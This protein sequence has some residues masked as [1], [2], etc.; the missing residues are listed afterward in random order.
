MHKGIRNE[1]HAAALAAARVL[2]QR[3]GPA[4]AVCD[5]R[6]RT[7][8][9]CQQPPV[10]EGKGRCL[11]HAGPHAARLY[12]ERQRKAFMSGRISAEVWNRAEARRQVNRQGW[13][14][15][16]NPWLPG[17]TIGLGAAEVDLRDDLA[18]HGLDVDALAPA[19]ADWLRWRYRRTQIDRRDD[20]AWLRAIMDTLPERIAKAGAC[21]ARTAAEEAGR[22]P[23]R[24]VDTTHW[25]PLP[26]A[27]DMDGAKPSAASKRALPDMPR[28]PCVLRGK[29]YLRPGRPR[30]QAAGRDELAALMEVY[31]A[32]VGLAAPMLVQC[33]TDGDRL[34]VLRALR[35]FIGKPDDR[36]A[37][38][39]WLV[40]VQRF[41]PT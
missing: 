20:G 18:G 39:A 28:A 23:K 32:N 40:M 36:R 24:G 13:A 15:K 30:T 1:E 27:A 31:R 17:R 26:W 11:G 7:G 41:R 10:R 19:V 8:A 3:G 9:A 6:T 22:R 14:W 38:E 34:A 12:R 33:A 25:R 4:A 29:G 37:R 5:A 35:E 2:V 16:K 21:P